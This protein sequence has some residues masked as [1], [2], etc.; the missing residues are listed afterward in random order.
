MKG[1]SQDHTMKLLEQFQTVTK[2]QVIEALRT[3]FMPV[4]DPATS[5]AVVVTAPSKSEQIGADL[6]KIGYEVEQRTLDVEAD[7]DGS[8]DSEDSDESESD[9]DMR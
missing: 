2:A 1:V 4:F 7:E 3:H 8:E 5:I 9:V 6:K